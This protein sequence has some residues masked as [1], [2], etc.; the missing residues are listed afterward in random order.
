[1]ITTTI[2]TTCG[3]CQLSAEIPVARLILTLPSPCGD[4][5]VA[6]TCWHI[7]VRCLTCC[8]TSLPW[9]TATYL[10]D[11]GAT[12]LTAPDM[13]RIRP[14]CPESRPASTRPMT[15]D[16]L[17]DLHTALDNDASGL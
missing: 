1:M 4:P 6:P 8:S 16:D 10:L 15:L 7:C 2:R 9:R 13:D 3:S 11:A 12:A 17:L 14:R 5:T